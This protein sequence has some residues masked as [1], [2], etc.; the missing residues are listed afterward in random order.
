MHCE[1]ATGERI[2]ICTDRYRQGIFFKY[3]KS[4]KRFILTRI[5]RFGYLD[6][7][8][9]DGDYDSDSLSVGKCEQF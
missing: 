6:Y 9:N 2:Y 1:K 3:N 5:S 4:N 8:S 7:P